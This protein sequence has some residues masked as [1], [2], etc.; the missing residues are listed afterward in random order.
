[1]KKKRKLKKNGGGERLFNND[2]V[3][4]AWQPGGKIWGQNVY[5]TI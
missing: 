5:L 3:I 2:T 4:S 1:M